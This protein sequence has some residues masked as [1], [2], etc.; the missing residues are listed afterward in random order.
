MIKGRRSKRKE[1][2]L[3]EHKIIRI[4]CEGQNNVTEI[5]YFSN[6]KKYASMV[7]IEPV[8]SGYTDAK[9]I[10]T[11]AIARVNNDAKIDLQNG[12]SVWCVFDRNRNDD[13]SLQEA[14]NTAQENG[15]QI[16]FSNPCFEFWFL[17]HYINYTTTLNDCEFTIQKLKNYIQDY[18]KSKDCFREISSN[19]T[20]AIKRAKKLENFHDKEGVKKIR[21]DSN[22]STQVYKLVEEIKATVNEVEGIDIFEEINKY[23]RVL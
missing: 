21:E 10:V 4:F 3:N 17:I 20:D 8:K 22:P 19:L 23:C 14:F 9:H 16:C 6:F 1:N 11:E 13:K 18:N 2:V 15:I 5:L 7:S 12:D